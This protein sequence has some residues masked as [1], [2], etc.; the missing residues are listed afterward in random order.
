MISWGLSCPTGEHWLLAYLGYRL[1]LAKFPN[2]SVL[3][4]DG[5]DPMLPP[6]GLLE[7]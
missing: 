4:G 5:A 1:M 7:H 6:C 3:A 2:Q